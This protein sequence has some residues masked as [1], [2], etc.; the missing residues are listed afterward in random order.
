MRLTIAKLT[1]YGQLAA[2]TRQR[3]D[4]YDSYL[5]DQDCDVE[6]WPLL[7]DAYL[8]TLYAGGTRQSGHVMRRYLDRAGRLLRAPNIDLLWVHCEVFPFFP[9]FLERIVNIARKPIVFD[10]DDAIFHNYDKHANPIVRAVLGKK[11]A[12][13]VTS[14]KAVFCGNAYLQDYATRYNQH[15]H[16]VPTVLDTAIYTP[17]LH[18]VERPTKT[19]GWIGT[20]STWTAYMAPM[21]PLLGGVAAAHDARIL[22]VGAGH[23]AAPHPLLDILP[24]SEAAEVGQL[25]NMDIGI[26]PLDDSPWSRGKCGY[27]LIQYMACGLPVVASPVGVN[28]SIVTHGV[29]GFLASTEGEWRQAITTL[30]ENPDLRHRMGTAGRKR[31]EEQY[32]LEVWGPKVAGMLR[33][34]A[35]EGKRGGG[36]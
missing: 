24:W 13:I 20:P 16:I 6:S 9:G 33:E 32:S 7:D 1:K 31:V 12:P 22:S 36:R 23:A 4:Q 15:T 3:F 19:I 10:F 5:A 29:N 26:M 35:E 17:A 30:L 2:S 27:K 11:L 21:M 8:E 14:A 34:T 18:A 28:A 25:Q